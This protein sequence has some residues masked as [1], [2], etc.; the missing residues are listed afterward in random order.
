M[1]LV[2]NQKRHKR[3][4]NYSG[5]VIL[6]TVK[7]HPVLESYIHPR[8]CHFSDPQKPLNLQLA[9][10]ATELTLAEGYYWDIVRQKAHCFYSLLRMGYEI[11]VREVQNPDVDILFQDR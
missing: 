5:S 8:P 7:H 3:T 11:L 6:K 2:P 9:P 10:G 1:R 4:I